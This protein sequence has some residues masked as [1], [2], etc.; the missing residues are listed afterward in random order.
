MKTPGS[1]ILPLLIPCLFLQ[2][3]CQK[4]AQQQKQ[5]AEQGE[6][7]QTATPVID[8]AQ[9]KS[10]EKR[11]PAPGAIPVKAVWVGM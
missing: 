1:I 2:A 5:K 8:S 7:A 6:V 4:P 3:S 10:Q 9:P 11:E